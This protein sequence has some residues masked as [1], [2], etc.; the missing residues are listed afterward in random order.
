MARIGKAFFKRVR[1]PYLEFP[2]HT[3]K[4]GL[5]GHAAKAAQILGQYD[6]AIAVKGQLP[7]LGKNHTGQIILRVGKQVEMVKALCN[8]GHVIHAESLQRLMAARTENDNALK[9]V[10]CKGGTEGR[11]HGNAS[12][13]VDFVHICG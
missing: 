5:V 11:R 12:L 13:A 10:G 4:S 9:R 1:L 3:D 6:A 7:R 8:L 2:S